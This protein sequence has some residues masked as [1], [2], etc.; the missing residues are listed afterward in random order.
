MEVHHSHHSSHKKNWKEYFLEF[1]MLF[2]AVTLGFFA[3]NIREHIA[4]KEKEKE[5]IESLANDLKSDLELME[6]L[7]T[8]E[9][10]KIKICDTFKTMLLADPKSVNQRDYYRVLTNFSIFFTFPSNDKSRIEAE[11]KGYFSNPE[12]KELAANIRKYNFWLNDYKDL[13]RLFVIQSQKFLDEIVP[14]ITDPTIYE[15]VWRY[16]FPTIESKL[17]I[18]PIKSED[19]KETRYLLAHTRVF[20]DTY[21]SDIDSMTYYAHKSI[22]IIEKRKGKSR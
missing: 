9:T 18:T 11:T 10:E 22:A 16:P 15:I 2:F 7:K 12:N 4:D 1:F 5:V 13:D 21:K 14:K 17:G 8:Y 6:T 19:I 3:E 20:M